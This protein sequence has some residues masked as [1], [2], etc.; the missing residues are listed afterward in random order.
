[1]RAIAGDGR[2]LLQDLTPAIERL[3]GRALP[4]VWQC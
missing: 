4:R 1:V 3:S 2:T